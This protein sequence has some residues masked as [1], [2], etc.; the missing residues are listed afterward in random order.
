[1]IVYF[2]DKIAPFRQEWLVDNVVNGKVRKNKNNVL[3]DRTVGIYED[4]VTGEIMLAVAIRNPIDKATT[5]SKKIIQ[6]RIITLKKRN[7]RPSIRNGLWFSNRTEVYALLS[8]KEEHDNMT[9]EVSI[10]H[11]YLSEEQL[12]K[13]FLKLDNLKLRIQKNSLPLY[14][15]QFS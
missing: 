7:D 3:R 9:K 6:Q 14:E 11:G 13:A 12:D 10:I 2:Q 15:L 8:D 4:F 5:I 1:M